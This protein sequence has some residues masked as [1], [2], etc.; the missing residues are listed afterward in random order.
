MNVFVYGT[1][2]VPRIWEA[3]TGLEFT[4]AFP[5]TLAGHSIRRVKGAVYPGIVADPDATA[6]V[7]GRVHLDVPDRVL[8]RLDAYEDTFYERREVI[9]EVE[10]RPPLGA[11]AYLVRAEAAST[12]LSEETWSLAWFEANGL[13]GFWSR[14][15]AR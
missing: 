9:V 4:I 10:G 2:L 6:P 12:I 14:V 11:Q 15:F 1:L 8:R 7:P 13:E 3:V 5:A